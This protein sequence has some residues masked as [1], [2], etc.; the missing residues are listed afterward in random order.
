M[1]KLM[2]HM[3]KAPNVMVIAMI[4]V[5]RMLINHV[6]AKVGRMLSAFIARRKG[7]S[8]RIVTNGKRNKK[9]NVLTHKTR[10]APG[11]PKAM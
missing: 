4:V 5:I 11:H 6:V 10:V 9:V 8:K 1:V 2:Y 3:I 7:I